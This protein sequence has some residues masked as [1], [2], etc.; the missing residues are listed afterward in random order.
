MAGHSKWAN[1]QHRKSRQDE[2]RQRIW[3][4]VVREIMVAART[5]GGDPSAN[6]RLRLAIEK[7]K[8]ANM[9]ADTVKRNIDKATGNLE[10]VSYEEI[11]YEGYGIGG[12]A[13]IVDTMTD[14]RV[15]TVAEVRHAFS[16]YG[17]NLGTDG[18]VAFQFKHCGQL[19]FAPGTS[20]DKVMEVALEA[21]AEDVITDDDGAIEV[22]TTP[23]D[24]E[25]VKN[26]LEAAGLVPELAEVTMRPE[27]TIELAGEDAA[28]MQK[29]LDVLEDLDDVQAV[30]HN[31]ELSE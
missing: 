31:A 5:G 20:E 25:A 28:R 16:K 22:L 7:A 24:F 27:N 10:G 3:T 26:A 18:S 23:G 9:P 4:R 1:I 15:R 13:I 29:L 17:G 19:V 2:K 8:A 14:N 21:G 11:R 6:P 30:Y 12:A